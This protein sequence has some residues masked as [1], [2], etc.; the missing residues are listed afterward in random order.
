MGEHGPVTITACDVLLCVG[1]CLVALV[2][3]AAMW[4]VLIGSVYMAGR[5]C[6]AW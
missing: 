6:G 4:A 5:G 3:C 1:A 2:L